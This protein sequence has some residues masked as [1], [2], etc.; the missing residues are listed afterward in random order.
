M[1]RRR[2]VVA[3]FLITAH[4]FGIYIF[5]IFHSSLATPRPTPQM[6]RLSGDHP[7]P[8][9][10]S[11]LGEYHRSK[12]SPSVLDQ[13]LSPPT[14]LSRPSH[15]LYKSSPTLNINLERF[16]SRSGGTGVLLSPSRRARTPLQAPLLPARLSDQR[17][18]PFGPS[19][20]NLAVR[21]RLRQSQSA[22]VSP[23]VVQLSS[24][25]TSSGSSEV[26]QRIHNQG[27]NRPDPCDK[28]VVISALK[29]KRK[30]WACPSDDITT[31]MDS[32]PAAK[33]SRYYMYMYQWYV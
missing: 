23:V 12:Q 14:T 16:N 32:Q 25:S 30:R 2:N 31:A 4:S 26:S 8:S 10:T 13:F 3:M 5:L 27:E 19:L 1:P 11:R 21:G 33:R 9:G 6:H 24:P 29:Q 7:G 18:S 28:E 20:V 17:P 15:T 22:A